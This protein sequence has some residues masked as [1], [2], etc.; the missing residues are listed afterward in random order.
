MPFTD[1]ELKKLD[2]I[3][4][5]TLVGLVPVVNLPGVQRGERALSRA[6]G[7]HLLG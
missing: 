1:A 2:L 6:P 7:P 4:V 5:P 3:Q